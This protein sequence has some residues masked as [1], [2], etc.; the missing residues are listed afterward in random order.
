MIRQLNY[1]AIH[2]K[3]KSTEDNFHFRQGTIYHRCCQGFKNFDR[4]TE[5]EPSML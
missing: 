4:A 2:Q 5:D 3:R 1:Y